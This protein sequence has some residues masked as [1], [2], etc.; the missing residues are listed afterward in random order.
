M[1]L[2]D[3]NIL[4]LGLAVSG[5]ST[6]KALSKLGANVIVT[7]MKK[8]EE[9]KEYIEELKDIHITYVLG[10]NDVDLE[11]IDLIIKSPGIP[12]DIPIIKNAESKG[13]EVITDIELSYRISKNR[14]I[15][16]T[17]TNGKT[18]TTSLTGE[19]FKKAGFGTHVTGNIG[20]GILWEVVNS[21]DDDV[22][23]IEASSFQLDSTKKFKPK[24][25][26]ITNITPD[27]LNWH[28]T[29]ENYIKAKQKVFRNQD[30]DDFTILNYDDH[31]LRSMEKYTSGNLIFFSSSNVLSKGVYVKDNY[32]VVNDGKNIKNVISLDHIKIPG[33]HNLE[34]AL[35]AVAI[36][37]VMG[38]SIDVISDVLM[39]FEG[40]E[41]R[42]EFVDEIK[43]VR[44]FND[45][46]G[47]NPDAS[48]KAI[49]AINSPIILIA[50]GMDK[51]G[52]FDDFVD[53]FDNKVKA[54]ILIGETAEKIKNTAINKKFSNIYIVET[55]QEAVQKS[56][57]IS[58]EGD[59]VLL[60]PACASWD[61]FESY[62]ERGRVFKK[63]VKLLREA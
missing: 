1:N 11:K 63:E 17:G 4:V 48:I 45:S 20:V 31:I 57:E 43:K 24:V 35:S 6:S 25:S 18:T 61:M 27:H 10:S 33:K 59:N 55:I 15:A 30:K 52:S 3:K 23:I 56:F 37:W 16:I 8:E 39:N 47:T 12:L 32:I 21:H 7:D 28:K 49:E 38:V 42:L 41:H 46:K 53:S 62:E 14:F 29:I 36:A 50:G 5:V 51:G 54:L 60:S 22:F 58:N 40:V 44:Y 2:K 19:I 9:L 26:L 13:I 34:N